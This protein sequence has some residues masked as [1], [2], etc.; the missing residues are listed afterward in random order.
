M[1]K[2]DQTLNDISQRN[3]TLQSDHARTMAQ[4]EINKQRYLDA[5][6]KLKELGCSSVEEAEQMIEQ[7]SAE[8]QEGLEE[9]VEGLQ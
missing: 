5:M 6:D 3:Q 2:F 7:L 4:I 8:I 9:I 1:T